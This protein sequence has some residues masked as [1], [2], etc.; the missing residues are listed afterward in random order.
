M[1]APGILIAMLALACAC[2]RKAEEPWAVPEIP[3]LPLAE[4]L[5]T[6]VPVPGSLELHRVPADD[7]LRTYAVA[8]EHEVKVRGRGQSSVAISL[9]E[10]FEITE[11]EAVRDG[12]ADVTWTVTSADVT[13]DP[14]GDETGPD[15]EDELG[16]VVLKRSLGGAGV[17]AGEPVD[18]SAREV[19]DTM[20]RLIAPLPD[21]KVSPGETWPF[22]SASV[23]PLDKAAAARLERE[24][25]VRFAGMV[26]V[27]ERDLALLEASWDVR[28]SGEGTLAGR[29][30]RV[31]LGEGGGQAAYL[32]DPDTG[33]T[34]QADA[35]EA[36]HLLLELANGARPQVLEQATMLSSELR[37]QEP[38]E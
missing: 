32:I 24:G 8:I 7:T 13:V 15:I 18:G 28:M 33:V 2:G 9:R 38:E 21:R 27:G 34:I 25:T 29:K 16:Q 26:T 4:G 6:S 10:E 36:T 31:T 11:R 1:R 23:R 5:V 19:S 12:R 30:G 14:A 3:S 22:R 37:L 17:A 20:D 35:A